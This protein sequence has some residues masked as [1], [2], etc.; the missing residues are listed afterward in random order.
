MLIM[1]I[2]KTTYNSLGHILMTYKTRNWKKIPLIMNSCKRSF[3][4]RNTI[5]SPQQRHTF[6]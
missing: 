4:C 1:V 2:T 5:Q 3:S 6:I